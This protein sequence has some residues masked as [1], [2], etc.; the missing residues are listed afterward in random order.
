MILKAL[1]SYNRQTEL[2][3]ANQHNTHQT[4][5]LLM[6]TAL[7]HAVLA[8]PPHLVMV[9][10]DDNGWAGVGYNNP[11]LHTPTLDALAK[12]GLI[13]TSHYV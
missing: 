3:K 13:L 1:L 2:S 7:F 8:V 5:L 10:T 6:L 9:L 4:F 12:D 11:N